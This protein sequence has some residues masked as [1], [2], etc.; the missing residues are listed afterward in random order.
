MSFRLFLFYCAVGGA[1]A[2]FLAGLAKIT[3]W[4]ED[5]VGPAVLRTGLIA[6]TLGFLL[7][8]AV[9]AV[10]AILNDRGLRRF[11]RVAVCLLAGAVCGF[12]CGALGQV[13]YDRLSIPVVVSWV[14]VGVCIG[15]SIGLFDLARAFLA[16]QA[17]SQAVKK[18][19]N[20][21]IGGVIGGILGGLCTA[22]LEVL[23]TRLDRTR[24][25]SGQVLLGA[26]I[27]LVI[28]LA[29]VILKEAW[30]KVESGFWAGRELMLSREVTTVGRAEFCDIGL[31][32]DNAVERL[33]ARILLRDNRYLVAD[34]GSAAG[35]F[36]NDERVHQ[37][38]V[39][40]SGDAIRV[41]QTVLRFGERPRRTREERAARARPG[42]P[43]DQ[44]S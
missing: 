31:F 7:G 25:I 6:A 12:G 27:G 20:G 15:V 18:I 29:Q 30:I 28:G 26:S 1:W 32:G 38:T 36:V 40:R 22:G 23:Q 44:P 19:T 37:P 14:L 33:H 39:L 16:G 8:G 21:V 34:E 10:D 35:T 2:G 13:L 3:V 5:Q 11:Q 43:F 42:N 17:R 24:Q 41:G 4:G 9:S